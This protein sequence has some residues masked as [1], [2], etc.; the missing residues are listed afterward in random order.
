MERAVRLPLEIGVQFVIGLPELGLD[1]A[2]NRMVRVFD[3]DGVIVSRR[4]MAEVRTPVGPA[5]FSYSVQPSKAANA[6]WYTTTP[7]PLRT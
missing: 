5:E 7:L 3:L 2:R 6:K 4:V 1:A